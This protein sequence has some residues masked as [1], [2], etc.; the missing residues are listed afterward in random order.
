MLLI[1][2]YI[3]RNKNLS[4]T[5]ML[6]CAAIYRSA[7][8]L[9]TDEIEVYPKDLAEQLQYS[10]SLISAALNKLFKENLIGRAL[11][12]GINYVRCYHKCYDEPPIP[13]PRIYY[14]VSPYRFEQLIT[15]FA[16]EA[17]SHCKKCLGYG[18]RLA[19]HPES[20]RRDDMMQCECTG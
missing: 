19:D 9:E 1:P 17:S 7:Q 8:I 14:G 13:P 6:V 16:R 10:E 2:H 12:H 5:D 18:L 11:H 3:F 20:W 15:L 4:A